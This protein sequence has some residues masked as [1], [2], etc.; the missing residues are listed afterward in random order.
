MALSS[1]IVWEVRPTVGSDN[2]GGGYKTGASGTDYSQQASAQYALTGIASAGAGATILSA[3]AAADMVGNIAQ[4]ISGTNFTAGFYEIISVSVGVSITFDRS[5]CTGVGA[6]GVINIGGALNTISIVAA[7]MVSN[8]TVYVKAS[9]TYTVT[10]TLNIT[11]LSLV[12]FI[13][14]TTTRGDNGRVSWTTSTN[15]VDLISCNGTA[16][17]GISFINF[18]FSNTASTRGKGVTVLQ[19]NYTSW[20]FQ[21]CVFDGFTT[22]VESDNAIVWYIIGLEFIS[23]EIK[24]CSAYGVNSS[25]STVFYFCRIHNCAT[26]G[27]FIE[28]PQQAPNYTFIRC[29]IYAN[30]VGIKFASDQSVI[31]NFIQSVLYANI[32]TGLLKINGGDSGTSRIYNI[33]NSVIYGNGGWGIDRSASSVSIVNGFV[34]SNAFG[35]NTS[36]DR[37]TFTTGVATDLALTADPFTNGAAG[38]FS[39]NNISGGGPVCKSAGFDSLP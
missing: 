13:G 27:V 5:V 14:Y 33:L 37:N 39:L 29:A 1:S 23:C 7:N 26:A 4:V 22:G 17:S 25:W 34:Q 11:A 15:S 35:A 31:L 2:N 8:N 9:G 36:G 38:D 32:G 21:N 12:S 28:S 19:Q 10:A 18:S 3:A 16:C 20:C 6:S 30:G 24:N